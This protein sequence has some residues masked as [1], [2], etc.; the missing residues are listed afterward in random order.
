MSQEI[1]CRGRTGFK[2]SKAAISWVH[3]EETNTLHF[4]ADDEENLEF[5]L[6]FEIPLSSLVQK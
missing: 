4:R 2:R 3:N 5:W 1:P 6:E